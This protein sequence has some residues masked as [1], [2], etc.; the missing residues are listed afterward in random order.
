M[1][2]EN[3][4]R[5]RHGIAAWLALVLGLALGCGGSNGSSN[6]N[7]ATNHSPVAVPVAST[8][9]IV[10]G[11]SI[12]LNA[13]ATDQDG[14]ALTYSWSQ[15]SPA[16]PQGA[17]SST[18]SDSPSWTA[19]TVG[20]T[21][22]FTLAV[23]VSD[24]KGA[25]STATLIVYAKTSTDPSF[26]AEV[27]TALA[28]VCASCHSGGGGGP[29]PQMSYAALV[30]VPATFS[31]T[32]EVRV[33]PGDPDHSVLYQRMI[34]STCGERMPPADQAYYDRATDELALVRT[35]IEAGAPDN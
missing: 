6:N 5:R 30:N 35:W 19:P 25:S 34:G 29:P 9:A 12:D 17:F 8:I 16:S 28:K 32:S 3:A 11:H 15:A 18:S 4:S 7:G 24:S 33:K 27:S 10:M 31:C 22:A 2:R 23:K 20:A 21:T 13:Q 26:V 14:D 1:I